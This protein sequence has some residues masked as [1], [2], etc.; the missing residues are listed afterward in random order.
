MSEEEVDLLVGGMEDNQGQ[1]NYEGICPHHSELSVL[2]MSLLLVLFDVKQV[3][4]SL[5]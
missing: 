3:L 5:A 4:K 2:R 1:I